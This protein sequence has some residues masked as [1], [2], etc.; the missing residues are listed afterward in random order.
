MR[1]TNEQKQAF[2][3]SKDGKRPFSSNSIGVLLPALERLGLPLCIFGVVFLCATFFLTVLL[4]PDR[5][6]VRIGERVIR[7]QDL[8]SEEK[9][10]A[11]KQAKLLM[12][13]AKLSE[14][15]RSS[16][17]HDV[18]KLKADIL[19]WGRAL[20]SIDEVRRSFATAGSDPISLPV[21]EVRGAEGKILLGGEVRD[22]S[23]R[24]IQLLASFVDGLRKDPLFQSVSEPEYQQVL[25]PNGTSVSSFSITLLLK[26]E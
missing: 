23:G 25:E 18:E 4:T 26:R 16:M 2:A 17:L 19:P 6:P 21:V 10:L 13:R 24:S 8:E 22:A 14:E 12:L 9:F 7:V 15:S 1:G 3:T 5:F 20:L 11:S